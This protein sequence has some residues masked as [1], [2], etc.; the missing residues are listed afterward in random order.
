MACWDYGRVT[1]GVLSHPYFNGKVDEEEEKVRIELGNSCFPVW[2]S[3]MTLPQ[4]VVGQQSFVLL[5]T[6]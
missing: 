4:N 6:M 3:K 1:L 2:V 5:E